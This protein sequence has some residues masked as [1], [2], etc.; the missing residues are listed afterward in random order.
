MDRPRG[1]PCPSCGEPMSDIGTHAERK[2]T[3]G[4]CGKSVK[5]PLKSGQPPLVTTNRDRRKYP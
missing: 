1:K 2:C 5:W 3:N 4:K